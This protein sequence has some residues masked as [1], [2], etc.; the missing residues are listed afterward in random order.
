VD[1]DERTQGPVIVATRGNVVVREITTLIDRDDVKIWEI[2]LGTRYPVVYCYDGGG[3]E[4]NESPYA[5]VWLAAKSTSE[6]ADGRFKRP[7]ELR[8]ELPDD[9]DWRVFNDHHDGCTVQVAAY[10]RGKK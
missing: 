6:F 10:R 1:N 8:F 2:R 9:G 4:T 5:G 7:T 3:G